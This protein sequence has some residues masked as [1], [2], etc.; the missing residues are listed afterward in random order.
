MYLLSRRSLFATF[1]A[2]LSARLL[3]PVRAVAQS[4]KPV[5]ITRIEGFSI[6]IPIPAEEA[7]MG[8]NSRYAVVRLETDA[9]V[10]GYSFAGYGRGLGQMLFRDLAGK[11]LFAVED[12]LKA[13]LIRAGGVEHAVWDAIGKI[14]RQPVYRLLGGSQTRVKAYRLG[15][16]V[17]RE[18]RR[19]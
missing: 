1:G 5:R 8:K 11:D 3:E 6:Q 16:H 19:R 12:H 17:G 15:G 18:A 7:A 9:G 4:V 2:T 14:A 10:R 13:G